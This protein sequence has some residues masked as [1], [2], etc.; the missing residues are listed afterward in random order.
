MSQKPEFIALDKAL[1]AN[2]AKYRFGV[3]FRN[4]MK[5]TLVLT[6]EEMG[7]FKEAMGDGV[8]WDLTMT[9]P[10]TEESTT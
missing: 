8:T 3:F 5:G 9:N 4:V 10:K 2:G 7:R 6:E 1:D